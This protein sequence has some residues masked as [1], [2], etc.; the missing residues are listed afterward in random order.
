MRWRAPLRARAALRLTMTLAALM[1]AVA[2]VGMG[3][4]YRTVARA[5]EERQETLLQ[6]DL[7][8]LAALYEER[9]I[10][11]L[12]QALVLRAQVGG[13]GG[14]LYLL[15]DKSGGKLAGNLDAWPAEVAA[16]GQGFTTENRQRFQHAG[17][18]YTGVARVLDGGFPLLVAWPLTQVD[19]VLGRLKGVIWGVLAV[20]VA[21]ALVAGFATAHYVIGRIEGMNAL[22][23]RVSAGELDVRFDHDRPADEYGILERRIEVMLERI[24]ALQGA[25][26]RLSDAIAHELRTPL[27]RIQARLS[28]LPADAPGVAEARE[29]L[30]GTV[31][32]FDSLL[33]IASAEAK[34]GSAPGLAPL[35]LDRVAAEVIELYAPVAEDRGL[36]LSGNLAPGCTVL[37]DRQLVAQLISNLVDNALKFTRPGDSVTVSARPVGDR[38]LL[39]VSDTGPGLPDGVGDMAFERFVRAERDQHLSGHGLG[40]A[41][42]RAIATRHGAKLRI[43]DQKTGFAIEVAWPRFDAPEPGEGR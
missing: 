11:A 31:R 43:R 28:R 6:A 26:R 32:I 36:I 38:H 1:I 4:Q 7:D 37:G 15:L 8:G 41:L 16:V 20:T 9:R 30:R 34:Q 12:R 39:T 23:E 14:P 13:E 19:A 24:Q 10:P 27:G 18:A 29:E 5:L 22:I 17:T 3:L 40:L 33:D 25:T 2:L 21:V 42:V 35:D